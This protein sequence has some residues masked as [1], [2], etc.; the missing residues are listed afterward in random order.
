MA[1]GKIVI[2]GSSNTD[3]VIKS[4]RIPEPGETILGGTFLMN[5]GGKGANQAV[6]VSRLGGDVV[7]VTKTGNDLFG[8]QS[9][10]LYTSEGINTDYILSDAKNPSGV[11]I[12]MVDAKGENCIAVASG[13]NGTLLPKD[14]KAARKEIENAEIVLM[15]M[16]IP[17]ETIQHVAS[18]AS[19]KGVKVILNPAPA[20]PLSDELLRCLYIITPN[21]S[22]TEMIT[23]IKVTD[24]ES[25]RRAADAISEKGVGIVVITLG[26]LGA[27]IK[28][29]STYYNV[30][31]EKVTAVDTT[32]AGDVFN[33]A[34]CVALAE[35]KTTHEA[36]K[37]AS[38]AASI[39][40]TRMGAQSSIPSRKELDQLTGK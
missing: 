21:K 37:F 32:A 29:D 38:K 40:V 5:P 39:A 13:A 3:M 4:E 31:A 28:E 22:E 25:A 34:L 1:N 11:A 18:I 33:G 26:S 20:A 27:L 10:E 24:W 15:Q 36:V 6:A 9:V 16:E 14:T 17:M 2:V 8:R 12:I 30:P 35:G 7:F 19:K 23:G